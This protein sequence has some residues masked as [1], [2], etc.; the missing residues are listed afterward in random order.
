[1]GLA[2]FPFDIL[3]AV[4]FAAIAWCEQWVLVSTCRALFV[5]QRLWVIRN[6]LNALAKHNTV[7]C[8]TTPIDARYLTHGQ[9]KRG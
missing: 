2:A 5:A 6:R 4:M 8:L 7:L 1:M 3:R 9:T